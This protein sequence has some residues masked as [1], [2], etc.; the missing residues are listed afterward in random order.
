MFP[1]PI[2]TKAF[3]DF[4]HFSETS[5]LYNSSLSFSTFASEGFF[6]QFFVDELLIFQEFWQN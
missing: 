3:W 5:L 1:F 6:G 2:A 4:F